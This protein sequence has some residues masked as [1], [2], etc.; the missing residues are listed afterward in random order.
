M[1]W[2]PIAEAM[3]CSQEWLPP[4]QEMAIYLYAEAPELAKSQ[5]T[6][7]SATEFLVKSVSAKIT[8]QKDENGKVSRMLVNMGGQEMTARRLP[9]FDASSLNLAE[10]NRRFL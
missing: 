10:L 2:L 9:D 6:P 3:N 1:Y 8:F 5:M 4:F 7:L